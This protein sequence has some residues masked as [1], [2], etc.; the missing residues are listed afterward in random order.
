[1]IWAWNNQHT[2]CLKNIHELEAHLS[3]DGAMTISPIRHCTSA[4]GRSVMT[5]EVRVLTHGCGGFFA[6]P[7]RQIL[8]VCVYLSHDLNVTWGTWMCTY[9]AQLVEEEPNQGDI[10]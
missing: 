6:F 1:M 4:T 9:R 5:I 2:S 10:E 7:A 3:P 8:P